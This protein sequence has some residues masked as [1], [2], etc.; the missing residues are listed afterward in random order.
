MNKSIKSVVAASVLAALMGSNAAMAEMTANIGGTSNYVWRGITQSADDAAISGGLD[1][2]HASGLYVGT[3]TSSTAWGSPEID[4]YGGFAKEFG[5]LGVDVGLTR[6]YYP[7]DIDGYGA[8]LDWTEVKG[9]ISYGPAKLTVAHGD[10]VFGV[11]DVTSNYAAVD[12]SHDL[13]EDLSVGLHVGYWKFSD[14]IAVSIKCAAG[15]CVADDAMTE[16]S[17]S[18]TKGDFTFTAADTNL[19][20]STYQDA[21]PRVYVTYTKKFDL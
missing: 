13:K 21:A 20:D 18:L 6:Y 4:L 19:D 10:D 16:Y 17:V 8:N 9:V 11:A 12:L 7:T 3:W 14:P 2:S 15:G 1:Y 5:A